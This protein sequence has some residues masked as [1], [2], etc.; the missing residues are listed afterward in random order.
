MRWDYD[1]MSGLDEEQMRSSIELA[2][3]IGELRLDDTGQRI[4]KRWQ[5][6][7]PLSDLVR[8]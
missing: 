7:E 4:V 5:R 8:A 3:A 1:D 6:R 2:A